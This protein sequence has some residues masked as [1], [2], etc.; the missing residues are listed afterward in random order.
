MKK[1]FGNVDSPRGKS[2]KGA[3]IDPISTDD[4]YT[5]AGI[6]LRN[7]LKSQIVWAKLPGH[8]FWPGLNVGLGGGSDGDV[9]PNETRAMGKVRN[10]PNHLTPPLRLPIL[11]L[12]R[13]HYDQKGAFPRTVTLT[14]PSYYGVQYTLPNPSYQS[15]IHMAERLT[16]SFSS[17]QDGESLVIFYGENSFGWVREDQV[18]DFK[19]AYA[20]KAREPVR[21]KARFNSALN[22]ALRD[23]EQ[24][25]DGFVPPV[26]AQRGKSGGR[27]HGH[28]RGDGD[29]T[30]KSV[31]QTP[32]SSGGDGGVGEH[33]E[34]ASGEKSQLGFTGKEHLVG[35]SNTAA[36]ESL[37]SRDLSAKAKA[38]LSLMDAATLAALPQANTQNGDAAA[39]M[40][41]MAAAAD[42]AVA[43]GNRKIEG[44][45]CRV[46]SS[47]TSQDVCL[48][49]EA[50]RMCGKYPVG[51]ML[52]LQGGASV[53]NN[54]EIYWPLD[55]V[56]Y[57]AQVTSYDPS[58]LQHMV[59]YEA[60][61]VRE[62]LC[63]WKEDV[64]VLD[65]PHNA[66]RGD[67]GPSAPRAAFAKPSE[68]GAETV[69]HP[70]NPGEEGAQE[71]KEASED[72]D[73]ALLMGLQ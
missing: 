46:C 14:D 19:L 23:I 62:F 68:T 42:E 41:A 12:R 47:P 36:G 43:R 27:G 37:K 31:A 50:Q 22:E 71:Q 28:G 4:S 24:R 64:K 48:R 30:P 20:E 6:T 59:T 21:N 44:C 11:V 38:G 9:V 53:G 52:A 61:G 73:A 51:A 49:I 32:A 58:E 29:K 72:A 67:G 8:P 69:T 7:K 16:L 18:L 66:S 35:S 26:I 57:V 56:H 3:P 70:G 10:F 45:A 5:V 40:A 63:L 65:G 1:D 15:L 25:D 2:G 34:K 39:A 13:E 33:G 54:I 17:C 60:D 55:E